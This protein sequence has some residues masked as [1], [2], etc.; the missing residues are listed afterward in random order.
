MLSKRT[1]VEKFHK[2][3]FILY[4]LPILKRHKFC[5][6][7]PLAQLRKYVLM[8]SS[9]LV[10]CKILGSS[11]CGLL[12]FCEGMK[13]NSQ[14]GNKVFK[15]WMKNMGFYY[16]TTRSQNIGNNRFGYAFTTS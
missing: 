14:S 5:F 10:D 7:T 2:T 4:H 8:D 11:G 6:K 12:W 3:G 9:G 13:M 16:Y 1:T 15:T